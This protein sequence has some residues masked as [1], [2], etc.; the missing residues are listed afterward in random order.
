MELSTPF[1]T[2]RFSRALLQHLFTI[3]SGVLVFDLFMLGGALYE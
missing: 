3:E 1:A 2:L